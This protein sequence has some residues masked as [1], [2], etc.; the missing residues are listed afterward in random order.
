MSILAYN[1]GAVIAMKGKDCV[2][3]ATDRRLGVRGHTVAL[4]FDK[5]Y[6]MGPNL[7][8]G[9]P[10]LATDTLTVFQRLRFRLN[11]YELRENR[12]VKPETFASMVSNLLYEK[13]FGPYFTEP[14]IA[15]LG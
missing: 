14:V 6:E 9:L 2:A 1:G 10:G 15:G 4:D 3:I 5:V 11:L 8:I 13:R 7:Y 12:R